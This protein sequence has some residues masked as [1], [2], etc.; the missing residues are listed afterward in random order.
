MWHSLISPYLNIGLLHPLEV[1]QAAETAYLEND[2]LVRRPTSDVRRQQSTVNNALFGRCPVWPMPCL[3][4]GRCPV[5]PMPFA[6]LIFYLT[7]P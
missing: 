1:I 4:D 5:W 7:F 2:S 3:A 6:I